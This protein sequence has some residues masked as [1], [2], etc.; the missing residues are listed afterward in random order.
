MKDLLMLSLKRIACVLYY[1][2]LVFMVFFHPVLV[3]DIIS[4]LE[5]PLVTRI[6]SVSMTY[7][8]LFAIF[9][10]CSKMLDKKDS[11]SRDGGKGCIYIP[12][13][14][15]GLMPAIFFGFAAWQ[16]SQLHH[17]LLQ[18]GGSAVATVQRCEKVKRSR[19]ISCYISYDYEVPLAN[20]TKLYTVREQISCVRV[21][22]IG[23]SMDIS[24]LPQTPA[25][26][27]ILGDRYHLE[28]DIS[29]CIMGL[30]LFLAFYMLIQHKQL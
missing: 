23:S 20:T 9:W 14:L 11:E 6:G 25:E 28:K 24:Y 4:Q 10:F 12:L 22:K 29:A 5:T 26:V 15:F 16:E 17:Q 13:I 18:E 21:C 8:I 3:G 30:N 7:A 1:L 19:G 2:F 27:R